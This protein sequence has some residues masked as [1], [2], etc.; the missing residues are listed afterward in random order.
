MHALPRATVNIILILI[1]FFESLSP[2]SAFKAS[3]QT[4]TGSVTSHRDRF[5]NLLNAWCLDSDAWKVLSCTRNVLIDIV[6]F[7]LIL[8]NV[9]FDACTNQVCI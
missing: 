6:V 5:I 7:L 3:V 8:L 2:T 4:L 9:L 1:L